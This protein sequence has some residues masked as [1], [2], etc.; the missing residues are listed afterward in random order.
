MS[1][2]LSPDIVALYRADATEEP[3]DHLDRAILK[4]ARRR[5]NRHL[6]PV[7][8]TVLLLATAVIVLHTEKPVPPS[9]SPSNAEA[10]LPPGMADGR[11]RFLAAFAEPQR[12]GMNEHRMSA[13]D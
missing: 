1:D 7:M 3:D 13:E 9:S 10:S 6:M 11:G 8:L 12:I 4:A 2:G 5:G